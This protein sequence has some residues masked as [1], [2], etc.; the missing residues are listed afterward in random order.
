MAKKDRGFLQVWHVKQR[1][2]DIY[3]QVEVYGRTQR[4]VAAE[5]KISQPRVST[6]VKRVGTWMSECVPI[7]LDE[8]YRGRRLY[9]VCR[10]YKMRL[11]AMYKEAMNAWEKSTKTVHALKR[12]RNAQGEMVTEDVA[13][14]RS[15]DPRFLTHARELARLI[16][17]FEGIK[18][19]GEV[20]VSCEGRL[21][22]EPERPYNEAWGIL[23]ARAKAEVLREMAEQRQSAEPGDYES[24]YDDEGDWMDDEPIYCEEDEIR[25][26]KKRRDTTEYRNE[27][28][29]TP[30]ISSA[31]GVIDNSQVLYD[32]PSKTTEEVTSPSVT[33]YECLPHTLSKFPL[34]PDYPSITAV[35][36]HAPLQTLRVGRPCSV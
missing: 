10:T 21:Y 25:L 4:E 22:E 30:V 8:M 1:D 24:P 32:K 3:E 27:S 18:P 35:P 19:T 12:R 2:R 17:E 7:G 6:I 9:T 16:T 26:A 33:E 34:N 14:E 20:D 5:Y 28:A 36:S 29:E 13:T 11:A 31:E 23:K 15:G